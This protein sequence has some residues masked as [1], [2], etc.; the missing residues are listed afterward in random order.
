M[1]NLKDSQE[2]VEQSLENALQS[3]KEELTQKKIENDLFVNHSTLEILI[4][5]TYGKLIISTGS[6]GVVAKNLLPVDL[7][8][9]VPVGIFGKLDF[10]NG[11]RNL[12]NNNQ[13]TGFSLVD[14][15]IFGRD[16]IDL[17]FTNTTQTLETVTNVGMVN[18]P[19]N[20]SYV[21]NI[22]PISSLS[23]GDLLLMFTKREDEDTVFTCEVSITIKQGGY[24]AVLSSLLHK[25]IPISGIRMKV[26]VGK[27]SQFS[28]DLKMFKQTQLG[29]ISN[30]SLSP[31]TYQQ[32]SSY[33]Q[34]IVDVPVQTVINGELLF[35]TYLNFDLDELQFLV[36]IP[37]LQTKKK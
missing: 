29:K 28:N 37:E 12:F 5:K 22:T 16:A 4:K 32:T 18:V 31:N 21:R 35:T 10:D 24:A 2:L 36:S 14:N 34:N 26:P 11:F 33:N 6:Y 3:V 17:I 7:N 8:V 9:N 25:P 20:L 13:V 1:E 27:E 30:D 15:F 19:V 23:R